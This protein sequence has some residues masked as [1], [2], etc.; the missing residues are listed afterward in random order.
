MPKLVF[1]GTGAAVPTRDD[2]RNDSSTWLS[3]GKRC[4]ILIDCGEGSKYN[5][6]RADL[7]LRVHYIF[8]TH[9]HY[10]HMMGLTGLLGMLKLKGPKSGG[11]AIYGPKPALERAETLIRMVRSHP[12]TSMDISVSTH[13]LEDKSEVKLNLAAVTAFE[14]SHREK[15]SLGYVFTE[16]HKG[17]HKVVFSGDTRNLPNLIRA[18]SNANWLIVNTSFSTSLSERASRYGHMTVKQAAQLAKAACVERLYLQHISPRYAKKR[19][20]LLAEARRIFPNSFLAEDLQ[21]IS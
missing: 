11:I 2:L 15:M 7:S 9:D 20:D 5:L 1:L 4:N 14:T 13:P 8:L 19:K 21:E 6:L 16:A 3:Y 10:D 18:A 17:D 12:G